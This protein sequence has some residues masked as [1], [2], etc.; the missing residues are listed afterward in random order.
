MRLC[1]DWWTSQKSCN[2]TG[3]PL[4]NTCFVIGSVR[5]DPASN[6]RGLAVLLCVRACGCLLKEKKYVSASVIG[7]ATG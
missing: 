2:V 3:R 4:R 6:R 5:K 7:P 1:K